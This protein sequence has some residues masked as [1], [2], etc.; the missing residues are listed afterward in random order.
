MG[1]LPAQVEELTWGEAMMVLEQRQER[2][3]LREQ[4]LAVIAHAQAALTAR[5]VLEGSIGEAYEYFPFWTEEETRALKVEK[6]RELLEKMAGSGPGR[7]G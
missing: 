5:C 3:R 1:L 6:Y 2:E 4:R 7:G